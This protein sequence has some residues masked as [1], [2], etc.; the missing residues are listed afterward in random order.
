MEKSFFPNRALFWSFLANVIYLIGM[1]G[2]FLMD[3][4][5]YVHPNAINLSLSSCIYVVLAGI[6]VIDANL[7]T[8]SVYNTSRNAY[9]YYAMVL[10]SIFDQVG[11][12]AY[13][14]GALFMATALTN[15]NTITI[16]NEVGVSAF[17]AAAAINMLVPGS[18]ILHLWANSL[19]LLGSLCYVLAI[20]ITNVA[21]ARTIVIVGDCIYVIDAILYMIYWFINRRMTT[22]EEEQVLPVSK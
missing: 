21:L 22:F 19:N 7:Q 1:I 9:R 12:Q 14:I 11:S 17:V 13:F 18:H 2:Y 20:I 6:F 10:S 3:V 16:C 8:L 4:F 15:S 5:D